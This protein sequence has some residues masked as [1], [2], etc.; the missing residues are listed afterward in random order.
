[1]ALN[2]Y[3][4][5]LLLFCNFAVLNRSSLS[6]CCL[7]LLVLLLYLV[8]LN[9]SQS[10]SLVHAHC[11]SLPLSN[12]GVLKQHCRKCKKHENRKLSQIQ[13][14]TNIAYETKPPSNHS[15]KWKSNKKLFSAGQQLTQK[16]GL[17]LMVS[18]VW[19]INFC[20]HYYRS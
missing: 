16:I 12:S 4:L 7:F 14:S 19:N 6:L 20:S 10:I 13:R 8:I 15:S 3:V 9:G 2:Y 5:F 18:S 1:M 11:S 17:A